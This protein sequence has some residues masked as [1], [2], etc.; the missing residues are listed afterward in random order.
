MNAHF[1]LLHLSSNLLC[2]TKAFCYNYIK[3]FLRVTEG[4]RMQKIVWYFVDVLTDK[5]LEWQHQKSNSFVIVLIS[6]EWSQPQM[7]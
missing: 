7:L 5:L 4:D 1:T 6:V 3:T 2:I